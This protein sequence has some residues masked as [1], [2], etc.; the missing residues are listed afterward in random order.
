MA[1]IL[2]NRAQVKNEEKEE[3]NVLKWR[4]TLSTK[5]SPHQEKKN[6]KQC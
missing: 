4:L 5:I 3:E 1:G 6:R 2:T